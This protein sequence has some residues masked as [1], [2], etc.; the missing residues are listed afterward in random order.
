LHII[1]YEITL[2]NA[3]KASDTLTL[4]TDTTYEEIVVLCAQ[5]F[6]VR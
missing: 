5:H 1:L 4:G 3:Q 2:I 6:V